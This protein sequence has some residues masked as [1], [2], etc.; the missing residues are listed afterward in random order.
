MYLGAVCLFLWSVQVSL[1]LYALIPLAYI[2]TSPFERLLAS[3]PENGRDAELRA[4][5]EADQ[6]WADD[7]QAK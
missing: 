5:T 3:K 7:L 6:D 1:A 4:T 2:S